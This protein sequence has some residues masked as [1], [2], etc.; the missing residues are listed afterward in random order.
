MATETQAFPQATHMPYR[1]DANGGP[2]PGAESGVDAGASGNSS[3]A[4]SISTGGL[5]IIVVIVVVVCLIG[6][7]T[8]T[9]FFLAKKREWKVRE[10]VRRSARKMV[11]ALTPRRAE[12]PDSAK[13]STKS[14]QGD[15]KKI[16]DKLSPFAR[17]R[18]QDLEK[19]TATTE[20]RSKHRESAV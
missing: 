14:S 2:A 15:R 18:P 19:G 9:L 20:A 12:F 13:K 11:T 5:V 17:L 8:A 1:G 10:K 4:M 3:G 6:V 16:A 7:T